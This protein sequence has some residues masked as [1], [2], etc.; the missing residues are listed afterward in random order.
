M[1]VIGAFINCAPASAADD[2]QKFLQKCEAPI[3][4]GELFFCIGKLQGISDLLELNGGLPGPKDR[5]AICF[6]DPRPSY[7]AR[8]QQFKNWAHSHPKEWQYTDL[9]G[10]IMALEELWPCR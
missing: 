1:L 7:G 4:S 6:S 10:I 5:P 3:G 8:L 9:I 2:V